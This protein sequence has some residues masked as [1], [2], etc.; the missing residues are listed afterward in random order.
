MLAANNWD[1]SKLDITVY[2]LGWRLGGK[3]ASGRNL[4]AHARVEEHGIHFWFGAYH[5]SFRWIDDC[6]ARLQQTGYKPKPWH[7]ALIPCPS[8]IGYENLQ[9]NR[10]DAWK[11]SPHTWNIPPEKNL[12][13]DSQ[14]KD[15]TYYLADYV[16]AALKLIIQ[17]VEEEKNNLVKIPKTVA[18]HLVEW[19]E[20]DHQNNT[21]KVVTRLKSVHDQFTRLAEINTFQ[22][23]HPLVTG[24]LN[25]TE[26]LLSFIGDVFSSYLEEHQILRRIFVIV[27]LGLTILNG[28]LTDNVFHQGLDSLNEIDFIQWLRSHGASEVTLSNTLVTSY[29][30]GAFAYRD[31]DK[32]FPNSEAGTTLKG[33]LV[34]LLTNDKSMFFKF[35]GSMAE[36]VFT[37]YYLLLKEFGV[38]FKF[39]H[40]VKELHVSADKKRIDRIDIEK[41]VTL[42]SGDD[43]YDPLVDVKGI[44]CWPSEPKYD[45]IVEGEEL[46][47]RSQAEN[48]NLES[49]WTAWT[50]KETVTLQ[51]GK[52]FDE[53]IFGISVGSIPYLCT[54]LIEAN[55]NWRRMVGAIETVPTQSLQLWTNRSASDLG[56]AFPDVS[57]YTTY[58][59]PL[60]TC[61]MNPDL[62]ALE[63]W[64]VNNTPKSVLFFTGVFRDA[65]QVPPP[66]FSVFPQYMYYR[67]AGQF[68]E[69]LVKHIEVPFPRVKPSRGL[70][71]WFNWFLLHDSR[72]QMGINRLYSQY[73]R[74]NIDPSERYVLSVTGSSKYRLKT[75]ETGFE[76]LYITGDWI[77]TPLNSG[78][79]E[80]AMMAGIATARA[81]TKVPLTIIGEYAVKTHES[82]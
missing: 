82:E 44:K 52:D 59:E 4:K 19:L 35:R 73:M 23:N 11:I 14:H 28:L 38:K 42:K 9:M 7:E 62:V 64:P 33:I 13:P 78:C 57:I 75:D 45:L 16:I 2:Q 8:Y 15:F 72:P 18:Q 41:Q 32:R 76:N 70:S 54:E 61:C 74:A 51:D 25:E 29:Y 49:F 56:W 26:T 30:D 5:N 50:G 10:W 47:K 20:E 58:H 6:Y 81:I 17:T 68:I 40:K 24:L 39:F 65:A 21:D 66:G 22:K 12:V 77:A 46:E 31:G 36:V 67:V 69:F 71:Q 34:A 48:V 60:S 80:G 27:D 55:E 43:K 37:P 1:K 53:V 79:F 3:C 63:D